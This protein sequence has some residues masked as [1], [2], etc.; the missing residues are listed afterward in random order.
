MV[1]VLSINEGFHIQ[2]ST[3]NPLAIGVDLD[4][5]GVWVLVSTNALYLTLWC[6]FYRRQF[7]SCP[8]SGFGFLFAFAIHPKNPR[9]LHNLQL[10]NVA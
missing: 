1:S 7:R 4:A 9:E 2:E 5:S 3:A 8:I 6:F 10:S